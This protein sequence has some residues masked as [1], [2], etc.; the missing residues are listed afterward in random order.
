[1]GHNSHTITNES[2]FERYREHGEVPVCPCGELMSPSGEP[3]VNVISSSDAGAEECPICFNT[4]TTQE[5]GI[6]DCCK[7]TFCCTCLEEWSERANTCPID[8]KIIFSIHARCCLEGT[9][10]GTILVKPPGQQNG[11]EDEFETLCE[12][13]GRSDH[14]ERMLLCDECCCGYHLECLDQSLH[15]ALWE[16]W[17]CPNCTLS[18]T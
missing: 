16:H 14:P 8:K 13:C 2:P 7:H 18:L 6:P 11:D 9:D 5:V 1:M 3:V 17:L 10:C 15:A 4:F 12:V